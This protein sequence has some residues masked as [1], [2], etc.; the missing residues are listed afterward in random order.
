MP[1]LRVHTLRVR[2]DI[3]SWPASSLRTTSLPSRKDA[4]H[5]MS[6]TQHAVTSVS[7][8]A[9]GKRGTNVLAGSST[10]NNNTFESEGIS[11][12]LDQQVDMEYEF[13]EA[14]NQSFKDLAK[15]YYC[16]YTRMSFSSTLSCL[17]N[18][19]ILPPA[20]SGVAEACHR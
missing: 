19:P 17:L 6:S 8:R 20:R 15:V 9:A 5:R 13:T 14:E 10:T 3:F 1:M 7:N 2:P 16:S 12:Q 11:T 4:S 18:S